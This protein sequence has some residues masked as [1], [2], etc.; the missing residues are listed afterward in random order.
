MKT[1][2][3]I[4]NHLQCHHR[5]CSYDFWEKE[6]ESFP[7]CS[8]LERGVKMSAEIGN[9]QQMYLETD[10]FDLVC[11]YCIVL[12]QFTYMMGY[13][14]RY[15]QLYYYPR[16]Q[17]LR[18]LQ[19]HLSTETLLRLSGP[20]KIVTLTTQSSWKE[21]KESLIF[22]PSHFHCHSSLKEYPLQSH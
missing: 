11:F 12:D 16:L 17:W 22:S 14:T 18:S 5:H 9:L 13:V 3:L 20:E 8:Q 4:L 6:T 7:L 10:H 15:G 2:L 21:S 1:P 19:N